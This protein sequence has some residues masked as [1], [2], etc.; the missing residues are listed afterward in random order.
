VILQGAGYTTVSA[1]SIKEAADRF[2]SGDF[3]LVLLDN[4]L[5][6]REKDRLMS[7]IRA[8]GSL[9]PV[10]SIASLY[11]Q[12]SSFADMTVDCDPDR[13]RAGVRKALISSAN[14]L[15]AFAAS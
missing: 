1:F 9:T 13:L 14:K 10:V 3:N 6:A 11:G 4:S 2:L 5:S 8:S 15:R 12:E 7:L